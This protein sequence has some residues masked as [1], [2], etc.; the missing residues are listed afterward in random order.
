MATRAIIKIEGIDFAQVYK[1]WDGDPECT[2]PFLTEFNREFF[3][4]R[5]EDPVYKFA[6]L[7]RATVK[8]AE[9]FNLDDREFT[10]WGVTAI[11]VDY[12]QDFEYTLKHDGTVTCKEREISY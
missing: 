8:K 7:L 9:K 6:Q 5:G 3:E 2:L 11:D 12:G 4:G 1:H 10:G